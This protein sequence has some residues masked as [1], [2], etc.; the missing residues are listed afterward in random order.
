MIE[1]DAE[2][3]KPVQRNTWREANGEKKMDDNGN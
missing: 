3:L 2:F 1:C